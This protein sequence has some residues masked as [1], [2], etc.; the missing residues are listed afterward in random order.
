M[1]FLFIV[2]GDKFWKKCI[3]W[4]MGETNIKFQGSRRQE[5][6]TF[7][8]ENGFIS[9]SYCLWVQGTGAPRRIPK[10]YVFVV[11]P[12]QAVRNNQLQFC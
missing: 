4:G 5:K 3:V 10:Y 12:A 8:G 6:K 9:N 7:F 1:F 2:Q 11:G